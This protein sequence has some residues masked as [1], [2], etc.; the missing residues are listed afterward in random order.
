MEKTKRRIIVVLVGIALSL[1]VLE[2]ALRIVGSIYAH[3]SESDIVLDRDGRNIILC[4]GDSVTFGLG[5]PMGF[6]YPAQLQKMLDE[7]DPKSKFTVI[8]RG[9]PG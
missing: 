3:L 6:S 9:R 2:V 1:I 4:I 5:A 7:S 8:N